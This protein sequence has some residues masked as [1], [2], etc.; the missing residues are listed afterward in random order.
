VFVIDEIN[1]AELGA[2]LGE[3]MMLL[4]YRKTTLALPYSQ[5]PFN[6]PENVI[7]LATMNT[8]DRSLALVD[9][10]LRR[11]F[12]AF[13][14]LP[15]RNVLTSHFNESADDGDLAL[16]FF[17]LVQ[18][19]VNS[20]DF[21]PGHSYWMGGDITAQ[22]LFRTWRYELYPYL[23]EYWFENRSQLAHLNADVSNLL[24]E[25]A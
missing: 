13:Q 14:M 15:D 19:R 7:L 4:E 10:A 22:G 23:A 9:F 3:L 6:V 20:A 16:E 21:A 12:H 24:A 5:K 1:R 11:R 18:K 8:A 2:V 25:E 17:D